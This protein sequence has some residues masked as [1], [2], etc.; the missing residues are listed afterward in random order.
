MTLK[1][2]WDL[3]LMICT[4]KEGV[5]PSSN[6]LRSYPLKLHVFYTHSCPKTKEMILSMFCSYSFLFVFVIDDYESI[7]HIERILLKVLLT[8]LLLIGII[9]IIYI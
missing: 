6:I 5:T 9:D 3:E 1:S 4:V 7:G 8:I 2:S